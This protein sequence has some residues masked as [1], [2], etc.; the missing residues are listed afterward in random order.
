[1][2]I[3]TVLSVIGSICAVFDIAL[4]ILLLF[5]IKMYF[6]CN[7]Y[8]VQYIMAICVLSDI[9]K[10]ILSDA[11]TTVIFILAILIYII[12]ALVFHIKGLVFFRIFGLKYIMHDTIKDKLSQ[13]A[14]QS[15]LNRTNIYIYGG[16]SKTPCNTLVFRKT[17]KATINTVLNQ[18]D[19]FL[20][21]YTCSNVLL[22][23]FALF[24]D[25]AVIYI[26][27]STF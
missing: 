23:I 5:K 15:N 26:L 17:N 27:Y 25:I 24:I 1:M 10:G 21:K 13:I 18:L 14:I 8:A 20:K 7:I 19:S 6:N 9:T 2:D 12:I 11:Q 3:Y 4:N 22:H 16:D